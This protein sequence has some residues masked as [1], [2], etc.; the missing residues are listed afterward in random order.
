M[1]NQMA[2]WIIDQLV[3]QGVFHFCIAPGSRSMPLALAAAHHPKARLQI[4]YDERGL[5]FYALG[6]AKV[7]KAPVA[8]IVTSGTA[9][10]NLL[11]S[12][13]EASHSYAPLILLTADRPPELLDAGANQTCDQIHLFGNFVRKS[14]HLPTADPDVSEPFVRSSVA[15]LANVATE[16]MGPL[17]I[18]WHI[19]EGA[20]IPSFPSLKSGEKISFVS[21][22]KVPSES[23]SLSGRGAIAVG[24]LPKRSDLFPILKLAKDL[25]W[26]VF[27]D[28]MSEAR[29]HPTDE[30]IIH[31]DWILK[32]QLSHLQPEVLL[33]FGERLTSKVFLNAPHPQRC[34]HV[35]P[36]LDLQDPARRLTERV[37]SDIS[38]FCA[39]TQLTP[40]PTDWLNSWKEQDKRLDLCIKNHFENATHC[41]E[42]EAFHELSRHFDSEWSLYLGS[43]M[44]IRDANLFFF[45]EITSPKI[46]IF[47][48]RGLSG[49]DGNLATA[50][51]LSEGL[52]RP[53]IAW[54][55]DQAALHDLNSLPLIKK[56]NY[57]I[58]LIISNNFGGGIFSHL[59][60]TNLESHFET[61]FAGAHTQEF[62]MAAKLFDLPYTKASSIEEF[63]ACWNQR[64]KESAILELITSRKTNFSCHLALQKISQY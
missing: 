19:R 15:H 10:G 62:G 63:I 33:H 27:A 64:T 51:G 22:Q 2:W 52:Q 40:A 60:I 32:K 11:P 16:L 59:P 1:N 56:A 12:V 4:H 7:L 57:P 45:P 35:S 26:P 13:M 31:F 50:A 17:H 44:P 23:T 6:L 18:N 48:N 24:R 61:L 14:L 53:L 25:G 3:Q 43:G 21:S 30:Q 34:I 39:L 47:S 42:P 54:V 28:L 36:F 9:V 55:G 38:E 49:I 46:Q 8:I 37:F 20:F 58:L 29:F 5:G 41:T